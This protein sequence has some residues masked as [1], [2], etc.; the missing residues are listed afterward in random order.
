MNQTL[1]I[2]SFTL[3]AAC[4]SMSSHP[5]GSA[6]TS[7]PF[8]LAAD[9]R[10]MKLWTLRNGSLEIDLMERGATLV[11]V[12]A[13]NNAGQVD[14]VVLGFDDVRGYESADNQYFGCTTGRVCNRIKG[15]QFVLDGH[16]YYLARNDGP[17]HLHGGGARSLDKV[18]WQ[19][20]PFLDGHV[21]AMRFQYTSG[22]GEEGYPGNLRITVTYRLRPDAIEIGYEATTDMATPVNLTNHAYWN[23]AG[24]GSATILDHELQIEA[25]AYTPVDETLIPT[26]AIAPVAS[27]PL[28]FRW[29]ARIG[30]RVA[31][32]AAT[33]TLGYDHNYALRPGSGVRRVAVLSHQKAMRTLEVHTDQPGLQ[34]YSGNFLRGQRGKHGHEYAQRSGLCLETQHFPDAVNQPSFPSIILKPGAT[35]RT[36]TIYKFSP[37]S[38]AGS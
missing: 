18:R 4:S 25:D 24:A 15:G 23:L 34:F 27:T 20:E 5:P 9:D 19:G 29:L 38:K 12:R 33:P 36:T 13:P 14:D 30:E 2:L 37:Y 26:G 11:A 8:G 31:Q 10:P 6:I 28:D 1:T 21:P 17:N 7:R 3:L 16:P 32:L 35:Y 22:D